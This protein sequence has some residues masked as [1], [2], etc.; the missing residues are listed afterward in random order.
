MRKTRPGF[1]RGRVFFLIPMKTYHCIMS[2]E[3]RCDIPAVNAGS[4]IQQA[5]EAKP[6]RTVE[7]CYSGLTDTEAYQ[8]RASG[9]ITAM[10]GT[11]DYDI[12]RH[13][14][15]TEEQSKSRSRRRKLPDLTAAMF[16]DTEIEEQSKNSAARFAREDL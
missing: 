15:L 5:L 12:P 4:A 6:G 1:P 14:A 3:S 10:A 7:R 11:Q 9:V 2:D 8:L 16:D 13:L